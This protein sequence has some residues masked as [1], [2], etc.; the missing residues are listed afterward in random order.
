MYL[1]LL[2]PVHWSGMVLEAIR[3]YVK[4]Q[5]SSPCWFTFWPTKSIIAIGGV[6]IL[7]RA[8]PNSFGISGLS[9]VRRGT[10]HGHLHSDRRAFSACSYYW[11]WGC[12]WAYLGGRPRLYFNPLGAQGAH[13]HR[14]AAQDNWAATLLMAAPLMGSI[15][16]ISGIADDIY[17][18]FYKLM[19]GRGVWA[20]AR[21]L[22]A[23]SCSHYGH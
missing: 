16:E 2:W 22:S 10:E 13:D 4:H 14:L 9:R 11:H 8:L 6:L 3:A 12:P 19:G 1:F 5:G 20:L 18:M 21:L 17:E 15:L 23:R 7:L